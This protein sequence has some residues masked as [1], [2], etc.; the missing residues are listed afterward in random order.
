MGAMKDIDGNIIVGRN[1]SLNSGF[2]GLLT[3]KTNVTGKVD[4]PSNLYY[5]VYTYQT[6]DKHYERRILGDA[7]GE[8]GPFALVTYLS[9]SRKT[10]SWYADYSGFIYSDGPWFRRGGQRSDGIDGGIF[11][12][13]PLAGSALSDTSYR[14]VLTP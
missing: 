12:F 10:N 7:T 3:D 4:L 14:V 5:D 6:D 9:E 1:S 11:S 13:S 8:V 2:N